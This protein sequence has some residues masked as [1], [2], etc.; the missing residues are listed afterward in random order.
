M[1]TDSQ[2]VTSDRQ[3]FTRHNFRALCPRETR[4]ACFIVN[5]ATHTSVS[6]ERVC[7]SSRLKTL[8]VC[9]VLALEDS[10]GRQKS[11]HLDNYRFSSDAKCRIVIDLPKTTY[12]ENMKRQ[13]TVGELAL[14]QSIWPYCNI[15]KHL[16]IIVSQSRTKRAWCVSL[17]A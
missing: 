14:V 2:T 17:L 15:W 3:L 11:S 9:F 7:I 8:I 4:S 6:C 5:A 1:Q 10:R 16:K 12:S 13:V